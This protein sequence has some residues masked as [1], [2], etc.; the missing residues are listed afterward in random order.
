MTLKMSFCNKGLAAV[1]EFANERSLSCLSAFKVW[2]LH[3]FVYAF[4]D[5]LIHRTLFHSS[6]TD[7]RVVVSTS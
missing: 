1:L 6:D 4:S 5:F 7:K 3:G 2:L